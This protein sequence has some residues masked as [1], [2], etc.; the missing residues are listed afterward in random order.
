LNKTTTIAEV[1]DLEWQ[2][3]SHDPLKLP[4]FNGNTL[5][6]AAAS[7]LLCVLEHY[8]A[9]G[10]R[11]S[12]T[13]RFSSCPVWTLARKLEDMPHTQRLS[14]GPLVFVRIPPAYEESWC[15]EEMHAFRDLLLSHSF[16][17]GLSASLTGGV[18]EIVDNVWRHSCSKSPSLLAYQVGARAFS[19]CVADMGIGVLASLRKNR[20]FS[21]LSTSVEAL[22]E[23]VKPNVSRLQNGSGLGFDKLVRA[24]ADFWGRT[25]LRSGQGALLFNRETENHTRS[26]YF[27]PHLDGLQ[28]SG[29][30]RLSPPPPPFEKNILTNQ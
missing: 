18:F 3:D 1:E 27:L 30:C 14:E 5:S 16:P 28:V 8:N 12:L 13:M 2:L 24:L 4:K 26:R 11:S 20:Q 21:Y 29:V 7:E 23:A 25:R 9:T 10:L 19:F 15:V 17:S 6:V 22:E